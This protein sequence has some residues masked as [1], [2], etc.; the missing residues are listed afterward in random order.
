MAFRRKGADLAV[1][2]P[3]ARQSLVAAVRQVDLA[4][5]LWRSF[6]FGDNSWQEELWRLYDVI[7]ELR[8]VANW[9]GS[10]CSRVRLYVAEVDKYGRIKQEVTKN[11]KVA[12]LS[13]SLFGSPPARAEALR[14]ADIFRASIIDST[15]GTYTI[16]VTGSIKK[17][18][19]IINLLQPLGIKELIRTGRV[20]IARE[21]IRPAVA[22]PKRVAKE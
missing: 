19:A 18:E 10:A 1:P 4:K 7:G 9:Q 22:Q 8:Y 6:R 15:P 5:Q 17:I 11:G 21:P 16:E 12:G 20:A 14:I 2:E 13:E 3:P